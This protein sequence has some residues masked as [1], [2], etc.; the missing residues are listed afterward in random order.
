MNQV[1]ER[2]FAIPLPRQGVGAPDLGLGIRI[3]L[4]LTRTA[5][6]E[7][8]I[9]GP[10]LPRMSVGFQPWP[11]QLWLF[12]PPGTS[13][14]PFGADLVVRLGYE[15]EPP[16]RSDAATLE[17]LP[18]GE[19]AAEG[20]DKPGLPAVDDALDELIRRHKARIDEA[21]SLPSE[22]Q[23]QAAACMATFDELSNPLVL[24]LLGLLGEDRAKN[25]LEDS[26]GASLKVAMSFAD[27]TN[28]AESALRKVTT[29]MMDKVRLRRLGDGP[30]KPSQQVGDAL[31]GIHGFVLG[32]I[33]S[34]DNNE[35]KNVT[36]LD[37]RL[38][39]FRRAFELFSA[40]HLRVKHP[41][42]EARP[43]S[44]YFILF[45][46]IAIEGLHRTTEQ[47]REAWFDLA[48]TFIGM[49]PVFQITC[50]PTN[51]PAGRNPNTALLE[52]QYGPKYGR[53]LSD[54]QPDIL[55]A[56][57]AIDE[58]LALVS[59]WKARITLLEAAQARN[60]ASAV[61]ALPGDLYDRYP[62]ARRL[63]P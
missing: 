46:E 13:P 9:E 55:K 36:P 17:S 25:Q 49:F 38:G 44:I 19:R 4:H 62:E 5:F 51:G 31:G 27:P 10:G 56:R 14:L 52:D 47:E 18:G 39:K 35:M 57:K 34:I 59:D 8:A 21:E 50:G 23:R 2:V 41:E 6:L 22:E 28:P 33:E 61:T 30:A 26:Y 40:R 45:G 11:W 29:F 42:Y 1:K 63:K 12:L 7:A 37:G 20:F 15:G 24:H 54:P 53:K 60:Y 16:R 58:E 48:R 43:D 3:P 32:L